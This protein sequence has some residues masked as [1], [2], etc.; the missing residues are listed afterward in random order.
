LGWY[1]KAAKQGD[2]DAENAVNKLEREGY[3]VHGRKK[4][5]LLDWIFE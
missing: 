5:S 1:K 2:S 3:N 4:R